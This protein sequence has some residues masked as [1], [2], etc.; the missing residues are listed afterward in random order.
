MVGP[1]PAAR[2]TPQCSRLPTAHLPCCFR[3]LGAENMGLAGLGW[4]PRQLARGA[5]AIGT[6][7]GWLAAACRW[8]A[9]RQWPASPQHPPAADSLLC[10]AAVAGCS[11]PCHQCWRTTLCISSHLCGRRLLQQLSRRSCRLS[12]PSRSAPDAPPGCDPAPQPHQEVFAA[13]FRSATG[14]QRPWQRKW[15]GL[16]LPKA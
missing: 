6:C 16:R 9:A 1:L 12:L 4:A 14:A 2:P 13:A 10:L 15:P 3:R 7:A 8:G 11:P 5:L